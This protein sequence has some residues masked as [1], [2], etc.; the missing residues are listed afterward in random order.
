MSAAIAGLSTIVCA[1]LDFILLWWTIAN[2]S[3]GDLFLLVS[4]A[5]FWTL[6][7]CV[8]ILVAI[9]L[10][11][12]QLQRSP[13]WGIVILP[14]TTIVGVAGFSLFFLSVW[15]QTG[16]EIQ[17][18]LLAFFV[19]VGYGL[20]YSTVGAYFNY[21]FPSTIRIWG[22]ALLFLIVALILVDLISELLQSVVED[23]NTRLIIGSVLGYFGFVFA[24]LHFDDYYLSRL[25]MKSTGPIMSIRLPRVTQLQLTP[26]DDWL[27]ERLCS[28]WQSGLET[29]NTIWHYSRQRQVVASAVNRTL[30]QTESTKLLAKIRDDRIK[31]VRG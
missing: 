8:W 23:S 18:G 30:S 6:V 11:H 4:M 31:W 24:A 3:L 25:R 27:F 10:L 22:Y 7:L 2:V 5:V 16:V 13:L 9:W 29:A 1:V 14:P 17:V 19:G 26:L 28:D 20:L 21:G 12:E 15:W